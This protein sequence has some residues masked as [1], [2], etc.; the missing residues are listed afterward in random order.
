MLR[1]QY[2]HIGDSYAHC[3]SYLRYPYDK[4][5]KGRVRD[6]FRSDWHLKSSNSNGLR[7]AE[8]V[9]RARRFSPPGIEYMNKSTRG[10]SEMAVQLHE[11][12]GASGDN[13]HHGNCN[14]STSSQPQCRNR[15][16][17]SFE[18][19]CRFESDPMLGGISTFRSD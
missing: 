9:K 5:N 17:L 3:S 14:F 15:H 10:L 7:C 4:H 13:L 11:V 8:I 16:D 18:L 6:G 2:M 1:T 19:D 12:P